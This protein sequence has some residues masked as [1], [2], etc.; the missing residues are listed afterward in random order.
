MTKSLLATV[1]LA[2]G[3]SFGTPA[4]L[5][6]HGDDQ[7]NKYQQ[8]NKHSDHDEGWQQQGGYEYRTY[9]AEQKPPGWSH[10]KKTGWGNCGL[11]PGQAKKYGCRTYTYQGRPYYY[12][13]DEGGQVF[14]RRPSI[15]VYGAVEIH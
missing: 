11:P 15:E 3:L 1:T 10:G 6:D 2:V 5:A 8:G 7:G 14:V 13:Q 4:V 9:S 12:Y